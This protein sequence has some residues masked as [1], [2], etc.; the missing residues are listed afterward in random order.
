MASMLDPLSVDAV[1]GPDWCRAWTD[2]V[3]AA[4]RSWTPG[5]GGFAVVAL[6][7]YARRQLCPG[8]DI[9]LLLLNTG[10]P[11]DELA[12]LVQRLC[13]PLWDAGLQVGH[14]VRT[15]A[16][17]VRAAEDRVD[18]ATALSDRRLVAGDHG[19]F[20]DLAVRATRWLRRN[21]ERLLTE[22][23]VTDEQRHAR[24][25]RRPG[26]LEPHLK[27]GA[28]GL[29]DL[30]GLRWAAACVLGEVGLDPL[31]NAH[32]LGAG[33][34]RELATAGD[35][36]LRA[37]CALHLVRGAAGRPAG[38][39]LDRLRLDLQEEVAARLGMD[40]GAALL[41]GVGLATRTV[42]YHHARTWPQLLADTQGGRRARFPLRR[43][44]A[45][46]ARGPASAAAA[47]DAGGPR[48]RAAPPGPPVAVA[49]EPLGDGLSLQGG[50][51]AIDPER[52]LAGESALGLRA[53][54]AAGRLGLWLARSSAERLRAELAEG[55][56][57]PWDDTARAALLDLLRAGAR[58]S[59]AV[60]DAD[61]IGLFVAHLPEWSRVRGHPQR[62]PFH[63]Y[64]L[65]THLFATVAELADLTRG[66]MGEREV[67]LAEGLA[68]P[69]V[70]WLAAWLHDAGKAWPG[71]HST[72]G[73][74]LVAD[75][76]RRMG[77]GEQRAAAVA[78]LVRHHLLL[79][80]VA[81]RRDLDDPDEL[82]AVVDAV[83]SA[84]VL[85]ALYLL[86]LADARATGP[87]ASSPW[88]DALLGE[89]HTRVRR[90]LD[91][92]RG[93]VV[94]DAATVA[95]ALLGAA[96]AEEVGEFLD[97]AGPRYLTVAGAEEALVHARL[98]T[99]RPAPGEL[100]AGV[101]PGPAQGTWTLSLAA[102]DRRGLM[103]DCAGIL[104]A[105]GLEVL[106]ARAFTVRATALD[107]FVVRRRGSGEPPDWPRVTAD[108]A[109]AAAGT[110]DVARA[111]AD[112]E[113]RRDARPRALAA[114]IAVDVAFDVR[115]DLSRLEV[116]GPDAPGLLYRLARVLA[117]A[118]VDVLGARVA[119]FG[120]EV[121]DVFF[122]HA[123]LEPATIT[124]L[125]AALRT[126]ASGGA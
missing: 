96:G 45:L 27:D 88:R 23:A 114:P 31:V 94:P 13:Y 95:A 19:L 53:V 98:A 87:T 51:V 97:G 105:H 26:A 110:L 32:Y 20:D 102:G 120:P 1:P 67:V 81:T 10:W 86:S 7:S 16:D 74:E 77:F 25:G 52:T 73:A 112:R 37:R 83:G 3:D 126:A 57:L 40:G 6:G 22:L 124:T 33:A 58:A 42:A 66:A 72:V 48:R 92:G 80:D 68:D 70:L 41:R 64:D 121:R 69:A 4:L 78:L 111:V 2:R 30:A 76:L 60:A 89:L 79:F 119:T 75:W 100:R 125:T 49:A 36:L 90:I 39:E 71:D 101:R 82:T 35:V 44:A 103:A 118:G 8:S 17:A 38:A 12:G 107:W 55:L 115:D 56:T 93:P 21:A 34:R 62:N 117:D 108:L 122:L 46:R 85:D 91:G 9:D 11:R 47:V 24:A 61:A 106:D 43:L 65:D 29:R 99:P 104:A 63:R 18:T 109:A 50:T 84:Q 5:R 59:P 15:P 28:G 123:D 116:R 113:R 14:A 54:A